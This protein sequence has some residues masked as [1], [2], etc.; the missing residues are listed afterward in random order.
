MFLTI[1]S[2]Y[3]QAHKGV[4]GFVRSSIGNAIGNARIHVDGIEHDIFA[5][6]T[7]DYWRLLVPG[8]YNITASAIGYEPVT[9]TAVVLEESKN[10]TL[11]DFTLMRS[12]PLHW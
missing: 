4:H 2:N 7:G 5:A 6:N 1:I 3:L 10:G 9:Q 12:D 11:L 8:T